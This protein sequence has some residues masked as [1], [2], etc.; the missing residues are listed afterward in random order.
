MRSSLA[1]WSNAPPSGVCRYLTGGCRVGRRH[2]PR[3]RR[4]SAIFTNKSEPMATKRLT[5]EEKAKRAQARADARKAEIEAKNKAAELN[6]VDE[7]EEAQFIERHEFELI[8]P[9]APAAPEPIIEDQIIRPSDVEAM[10]G[11]AYPNDAQ[12]ATVDRYRFRKENGIPTPLRRFRMTAK[13]GIGG[14]SSEIGPLEV[15]A[16]SA[17]DAI[18]KACDELNIK[19][20]L[21][22]RY[23][24]TPVVIVE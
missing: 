15:E 13:T 11:K 14:K 24:W 7:T 3:P 19:R 10:V 8:D 4:A 23:N 9:P 1:K 17:P 6:N 21:R 16:P 12:A 2:T 20:A 18:R 22:H 5:Q